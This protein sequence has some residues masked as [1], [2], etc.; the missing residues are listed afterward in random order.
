M[1]SIWYGKQEK[2]F[3]SENERTILLSYT[4]KAI[5]FA[6]AVG[7]GNL[8]FGCP[9][10]RVIPD[11]MIEWSGVKKST[12]GSENHTEMR[13]SPE[14]SEDHTDKEMFADKIMNTAVSFFRE[15][16]DYA[17]RHHTVVALEANPKIYNTNFI[18]TTKEAADLVEIVDSR[19]F[20]LNLD[21][22]TMIENEDT[23]DVIRDKGKLINH[24]HFSEP[25]LKALVK[26]DLHQEL[27]KFLKCIDYKGWI[28][29][30]TGRPDDGPGKLCEM[31]EYLKGIFN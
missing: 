8:V 9:K 4:K 7:C 21:T 11:E 5:D 30:E 18:N 25:Y 2:L 23:V 13:I 6:E 26:R 10:N 28:S 24:V 31:M 20:L 22:G 29:I 14:G 17:Y 19:G 3:G 12:E 27:A 15:I 16:G 1:Q